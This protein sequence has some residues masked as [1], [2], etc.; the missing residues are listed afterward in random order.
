MSGW[1]AADILEVTREAIL[2]IN[3]VWAHIVVELPVHVERHPLEPIATRTTSITDD[4]IAFRAALNILRDSIESG[5]MPSG[6][7]IASDVKALHQ[8]A[9]DHFGQLVSVKAGAAANE[10]AVHLSKEQALAL[11]RLVDRHGNGWDETE[12]AGVL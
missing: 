10:I 1:L 9:A 11:V 12:A 6:Q 2:E 7:A 3:P 8:R 5:R 4:E